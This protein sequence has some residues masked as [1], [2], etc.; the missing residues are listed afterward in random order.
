MQFVKQL[1]GVAVVW[2]FSF[3]MTWIIGKAIQK[4]IGLRVSPME[5]TIGLDLSQHGER[6]YGGM[7]R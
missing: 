4:T 1:L 2:V 5:E 3:A 6:A 7:L